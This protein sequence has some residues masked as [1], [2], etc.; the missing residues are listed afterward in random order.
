MH[1]INPTGTE[2]IQLS[3]NEE[4]QIQ[5]EDHEPG[6]RE[7]DLTVELMGPNAVCHVRGRAQSTKNDRKN[8]RVALVFKGENQVGTIDLRGTAEDESFLEFDGSGTLETTSVDAET[9]IEEKIILFDQARGRSL[10]VLRVETDQVKSAGHG[11]SIA[12]IAA[13]KILYLESRG[14][15]NREAKEVIKA[16]F[17]R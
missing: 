11:A 9:N 3:D 13:E 17:L 16:G 4:L 6:S 12:P 14:I 10:P 1:K 8:W 5:L 7:Y 2:I 15:K